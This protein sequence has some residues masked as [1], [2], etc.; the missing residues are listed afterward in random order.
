MTQKALRLRRRR[1]G[2]EN[3]IKG[4]G[5]L[6]FAGST[7][8][9]GDVAA[10]WTHEIKEGAVIHQIGVA[11]CFGL[12]GFGVNKPGNGPLPGQ[13]VGAN[14]S[15]RPVLDRGLGIIG[16][17]V[18]GYHVRVDADEDG[19]DFFIFRSQKIKSTGHFA[20]IKGADIRTICISK[21]DQ[22]ITTAKIAITADLAI[23]VN[24]SERAADCD[25]SFGLRTGLRMHNRGDLIAEIGDA[26]SR[27]Q[28]QNEKESAD[29]NF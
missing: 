4:R 14:R 8:D 24:E 18:P 17:D 22:H 27:D 16:P 15:R 29:P 12:D 13:S 2:I 28:S 19:D 5:D 10:I 7:G 11:R 20:E 23:L 21:I 25:R 9:M 1:M 6:F 26:D 3:L